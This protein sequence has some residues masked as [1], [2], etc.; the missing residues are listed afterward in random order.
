MGA[1]NCPETPRQKMI[2]MM[3]LVYLALLALNV[4]AMLLNSFITVSDTMDKSNRAV[5]EKVE[6]TYTK[7]Y[8]E[9]YHRIS[10]SQIMKK[11][12]IITRRLWR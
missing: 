1:T 2:S 3:Y 7:F 5:L 6:D 9:K 10:K 8:A 11:P 12:E 4:S